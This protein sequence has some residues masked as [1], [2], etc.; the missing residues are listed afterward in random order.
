MF[1]KTVTEEVG[2]TLLQR[3][4]APS[5]F[6][7][8][9]RSRARL[10][11]W[12]PWV[13]GTSTVDDSQAFIDGALGQF[14]ANA[15]FQAGVLYRG[16]LVGMVGFHDIHWANRAVSIGY[17]LGDGY[18][19]LG[20]MTIACKALVEI[21][22]ASYGLERVEIRAGLDNQRSRAV[23]C[24]L[25]FVEEGVCRR[26]EWVLGR[27]LDHVIYG[28]LRTDWGNA[29]STGPRGAQTDRVPVL[30]GVAVRVLGAEDAVR[31][32][33]IRLRALRDHPTAFV[34]TSAEF[35]TRSLDDIAAQLEPVGESRTFGA[36]IGEDLIGIATFAREQRQR[37]R[38]IAGVQG[39]YV[40]A[41]KRAAGVG[42]ALLLTLTTW[43]R[44]CDGVER[45]RLSV[46]THNEA[47]V[48]L[49]R[50]FGFAVF[51]TER[52][53][54]KVDGQYYDEW[55]MDLRL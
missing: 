43:A 52:S 3:V 20:I 23:A 48:A 50:K 11:T 18:E 19:G 32:R 44:Q 37:V 53:A 51:G 15:G 41:D 35:A 26:A 29:E 33:E 1:Q 24:R 14:A 54:L 2:L 55:H 36:F 8:I 31:Y 21:A 47:A 38:H 27:P 13:D 17:W 42:R 12:L 10:R 34:T 16:E 22:F 6:R 49:Y 46:T 7:L 45:L 28:M 25:G 9:D 40:A 5:L 39:L 30:T 4:D